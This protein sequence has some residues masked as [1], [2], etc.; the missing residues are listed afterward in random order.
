MTSG[1][2]NNN[3]LKISWYEDVKKESSGKYWIEK[4]IYKSFIKAL[5]KVEI[6][7]FHVLEDNNITSSCEIFVV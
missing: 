3:K 2:N 5:Y 6:L 4:E 7:K 1:E